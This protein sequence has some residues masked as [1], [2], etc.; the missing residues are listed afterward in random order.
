MGFLHLFYK[1]IKTLSLFCSGQNNIGIT[2]GT[3]FNNLKDNLTADV[4]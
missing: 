2:K 3:P 1:A 4:M